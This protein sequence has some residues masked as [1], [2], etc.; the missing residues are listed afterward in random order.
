[1]LSDPE[2]AFV[3]DMLVETPDGRV[4]MLASKWMYDAEQARRSVE[5]L[6]DLDFDVLCLTHGGAVTE[7]AKD[8]VRNALSGPEYG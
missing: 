5:M 4:A 6:L 7:G 3:P 1:M 2:V 8:A